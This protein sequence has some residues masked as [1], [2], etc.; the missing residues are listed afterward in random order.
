[1]YNAC[2]AIYLSFMTRL[3]S[4]NVCQKPFD[5]AKTMAPIEVPICRGPRKQPALLNIDVLVDVGWP[6]MSDAS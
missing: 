3:A 5:L 4:C 1:M 2:D 6:D